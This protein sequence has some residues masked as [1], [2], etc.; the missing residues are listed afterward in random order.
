MARGDF[1]GSLASIANEA[2]MYLRPTSDG[3]EWYFKA[4]ALGESDAS[5]FIGIY[6]GSY[7]SYFTKGDQPNYHDISVPTDYDHYL[8]IQNGGVGATRYGG[9]TGWETKS[10]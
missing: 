4:C 8:F 3:D 6:D 10:A 2:Y 1:V 7:W 5:M 9:A